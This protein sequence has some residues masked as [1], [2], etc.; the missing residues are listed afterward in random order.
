MII[1]YK[2]LAGVIIKYYLCIRKGNK[3]RNTDDNNES[4]SW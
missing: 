4:T 1:Y 3:N 2:I